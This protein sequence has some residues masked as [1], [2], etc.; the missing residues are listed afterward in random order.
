MVFKLKNYLIAGA[1]LTGSLAGHSQDNASDKNLHFVDSVLTEAKKY[2]TTTHFLYEIMKGSEVNFNDGNKLEKIIKDVEKQHPKKTGYSREDVIKIFVAT[3][4]SI[5]KYGP[6]IE[7]HKFDCDD[8]SFIYLAVGEKFGLPFY[9]VHSPGHMF[10]RYD[11]DGKHDS[12]NKNSQLNKGDINWETTTGEIIPDENYVKETNL[13]SEVKKELIGKIYLKNLTKSELISVAYT[14][15]ADSKNDN[16]SIPY[17]NSAIKLDSTNFTAYFNR[18]SRLGMEKNYDLAI[19]DYS[20]TIELHPFFLKAYQNRGFT[21]IMK[22][23]YEHAI[24][25][26]NKSVEMDPN[27]WDN[28]F[29][30]GMAFYQKGDY[31]KSIEDFDKAEKLKQET[32]IIEKTLIGKP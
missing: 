7:T 32:S 13:F 28:Y 8:L 29:L 17:Y 12:F 11:S 23:D 27:G 4:E 20:K 25:D 18:G 26:C 22:G 2:P 15:K 16:S 9:G 24:Q 3:H 10:V 5:K 19:E 21:F 6:E 1:F 31:E 30:R 14:N